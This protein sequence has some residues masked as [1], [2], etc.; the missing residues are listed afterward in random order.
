[1]TP[2]LRAFDVETTS[3]DPATARI[4]QVATDEREWIVNPGV[5]IPDEIK[6]LCHI[7]EEMEARIA[8]APAWPDVEDEGLEHLRDCDALV[9]Q[10]GI[11]FDLP[12]LANEFHAG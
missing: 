2:V 9:T 10:N 11:K 5:P 1:M 8:A 6:V 7:D 12:V 4:W 3:P